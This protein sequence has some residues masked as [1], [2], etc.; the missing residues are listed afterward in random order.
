MHTASW[1]LLFNAIAVAFL[2]ACIGCG[3]TPTATERKSPSIKPV[4]DLFKSIESLETAGEFSDAL[5][6][7]AFLY[8]SD[9]PSQR[10]AK[11]R[12]ML[13]VSDWE[14][15][16]EQLVFVSAPAEKG[17][18]VTLSELANGTQNKV[19]G[20]VVRKTKSVLLVRY[21]G[22]VK[23]N[24]EHLT[25]FFK[26]SSAAAGAFAVGVDLSTRQLVSPVDLEN[27]NL[28]QGTMLAEQVIP[29]IERDSSG[30]VTFYTRGMAKFGLPDLER[31]DIHPSQAR[32]SFGRFQ[33]TIGKA[34]GMKILKQGRS[35]EGFKLSD[36]KRPAIAIERDCVR[37]A[38]RNSNREN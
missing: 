17:L 9:A 26:L 10:V 5:V 23:E 32:K 30:L 18:P 38:P 2:V 24:S 13:S 12:A 7:F 36:C 37:L 19:L 35:F 14:K 33:T 22:P 6:Q 20:D 3:S 27:W 4:D 21:L 15:I 28:N 8:A 16:G 11:R 1:S 29:G 31:T 34:L 25:A